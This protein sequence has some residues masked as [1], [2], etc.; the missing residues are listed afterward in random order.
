MA[1]YPVDNLILPAVGNGFGEFRPQQGPSGTWHW[2]LDLAQPV[3]APVLAPERMKIVRVWRDNATPPFVGYGPAGVLALGLG[4]PG[5]ENHYHLLAHL[6]PKGWDDNGLRESGV[7]DQVLTPTVGEAFEEGQQVGTISSAGHT[8][9]EIRRD[10][11]DSPATR[12]RNTFDPQVWVKTGGGLQ[13]VDR[14]DPSDSSTVFLI[15]VALYLL[16]R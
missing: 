5:S 10:P 15:L 13:Q 12:G 2:G 3:G 16:S 1:R 4:T 14:P 7:L 9:W 8:H 6:D 11:I